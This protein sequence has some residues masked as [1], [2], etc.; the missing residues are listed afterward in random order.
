MKENQYQNIF[1]A[2]MKS[3]SNFERKGKR[4]DTIRGQKMPGHH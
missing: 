1:I 3:K 2:S 4:L